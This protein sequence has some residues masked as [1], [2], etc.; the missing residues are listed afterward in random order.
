MDNIGYRKLLEELRQ[1]IEQMHYHA[2][3]TQ[4]ILEDNRD[5][6]LQALHHL[7]QA[8]IHLQQTRELLE[9]NTE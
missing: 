5:L 9:E 6:T 1:Q 7:E 8:H 4:R 3:V 2:E